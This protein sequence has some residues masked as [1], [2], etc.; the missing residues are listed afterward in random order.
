VRL[1]SFDVRS[2]PKSG[3]WPAATPRWLLDAIAA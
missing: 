2:Y 1:A 3:H